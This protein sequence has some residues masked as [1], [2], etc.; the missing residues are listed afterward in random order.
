MKIFAR[1][2]DVKGKSAVAILEAMYFKNSGDL[3][4]AQIILHDCFKVLKDDQLYIYNLLIGYYQAGEIHFMLKD[5]EVALDFYQRVLE[6]TYK[7]GSIRVRSLNALANV[8][9]EQSDF[10]MA[11]TYYEKA[12]GEV[13]LIDNIMVESKIYSDVANYYFKT[14][15]IEKAFH[16]HDK[17][18]TIRKDNKL[19]NSLITNY[20]D[21]ANIFISIKDFKEALSYAKKAEEMAEQM[22]IKIKLYGIYKVLS[23]IYEAQ[24]NIT[25]AFFYYKKYQECKD[26]VLNQENSRKIKQLTMNHQIDAIAKENEIFNLRNVEL[27]NAIDEIESSVRYAKRIQTAILPS[28]KFIKKFLPDSFVFYKPKDI[29][30][31]DFYWAELK[32]DSLVLAAADCTGHGV[33]GALVSVICNNSLNRNLHEKGILDSGKLL[34]ATRE[35]VIQKFEMSDDH[36]KDGMDI[37]LCILNLN[38]NLKENQLQ[39]SG[40]NNPLWLIRKGVVQVFNPDKQPIGNFENARPFTTHKITVEKG[41]ALYLFTDGFQDQFGGE[42]VGGKKFKASRFKELLVSIQDKSMNEQG[43]I[44]EET[45]DTWQGIFEQVDDICVIG[46]KIN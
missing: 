2:N 4:K 7:N 46:V 18:I 17:S 39:W 22:Q 44:L 5:Y 21:L 30:S 37:S 19:S 38:K 33:P 42:S 32:D 20:I 8:C 9:V 45:I 11:I 41:D 27:K 26:E 28:E 16:Y 40:A 43:K 36:V 23:E 31:G 35:S 15:N 3:N 25:E 10:E 24:K 34:D 6:S 12:M 14:N 29:V 13:Q 1:I